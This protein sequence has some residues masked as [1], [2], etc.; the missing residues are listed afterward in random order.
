MPDGL[1]PIA[2]AMV[3]CDAIHIDRET[4]KRTLLGIFSTVRRRQFPVLIPE[5]A[6]YAVLTECRQQVT[7]TLQIVDSAEEREPL[8]RLDGDLDVD[9]PLRVIEA[10]FHLR[11]LEFPEP[12]DYRVQLYASGTIIGERRLLFVSDEEDTH[13]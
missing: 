12:G 7:C 9:D 6:V 13:E 1:E 11:D 10:E 2:L 8:L 5:M 4:D 3:V